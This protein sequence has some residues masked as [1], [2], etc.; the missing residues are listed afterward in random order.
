[1]GKILDAYMK[2]YGGAEKPA[3]PA[4]VDAVFAALFGSEKTAA[5][6]DGEKTAAVYEELGRRLAREAWASDATEKAAAA[7]PGAPTQDEI[8][9]VAA[10]LINE[11][12]SGEEKTASGDEFAQLFG[13]KTAEDPVKVA[14]QVEV[15]EGLIKGACA[16][17]AKAVELF[18]QI[19]K[20]ANVAANPSLRQ[21]IV[22]AF[23]AMATKTQG[24]LTAVRNALVTGAKAVGSGA[25]A[26]GAKT[27]AGAKAVG[28][29][30]A[31]GAKAVGGAAK[32]VGGVARAFPGSAAALAGGG[33]A[34]GGLG[35]YALTRRNKD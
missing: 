13:E 20:A 25:S 19:Y 28:G 15:I 11:M 1:M 26:A 34:L 35:T 3:A 16:G 32:E 31:R 6:D 22:D 21:R 29:A 17:N 27:V 33:A 23:K 24:G 10:E 9:K 4:D 14:A 5:A 8:Q 7:D 30:A 2:K 12:I 18:S